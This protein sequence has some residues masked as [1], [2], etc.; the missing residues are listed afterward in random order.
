MARKV[1]VLGSNF[2]GRTAALAVRAERHGD[3]NVT[4]ISPSD[5]FVINPSLIWLPFGDRSEEDLSFPVA[6]VL[7]DHHS[8][9]VH[10]AATSLD[11]R[12]KLVRVGS[13]EYPYDYLIIATAYENDFSVAPGLGRGG[14]AVT[15][16]PLDDATEAGERWGGVFGESR[17]RR[18]WG[19]LG[20]SCFGAA[21]E[22]LFNTAYQLK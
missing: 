16:T 17:R 3:A 9:F 2:G 19:H 11:P 1:L 14:N 21:Y 15:I 6:P 10:A 7:E 20:A 18:H 12:A 8:E 4:F 5:R 13:T 22:F